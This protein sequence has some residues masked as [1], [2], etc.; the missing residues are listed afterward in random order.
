MT[1][2]LERHDAG[3]AR[4]IPVILRHTEGWRGSAFGRLKALPK[5]GK[6]VRSWADEDEALSDVACGIRQVIE[7]LRKGP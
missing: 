1:R 5:D 4:V 7:D 6:P 3:D 2:A